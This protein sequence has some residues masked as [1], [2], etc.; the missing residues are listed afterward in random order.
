MKKLTIA[1]IV[2]AS[3]AMIGEVFIYATTRESNDDVHRKA[4]KANYHIYAPVL[5]DT[6]YFAGERVPMNIYYVRESMDRELM[7]NMYWHSN[8]LLYMK[9]AGRFFPVI[10]PI[11]KKNGV[12]EDFKYLCVIESGLQNVTS[13][14]KAQGYW[15]FIKSTGEK[16]GLTINDDIDMR[17]NIEA[18]TEA[19]C[20]YLKDLKQRF[21]SWTS[22]AA[23][24]NCG[25]GGLGRR[26]KLESVNNYYD[27]R[28]NPETARYV[29]RILAVKQIMQH[30]QDYGI[31]IRQCDLYPPIPTQTATLSGRDID[32]Y[33]YARQHNC[34][35]KMLRELNPWLINETIKNK[36][37]RTY[38]VKLPI[39]KGTEMSTIRPE[40]SNELVTKL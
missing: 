18:S 15:Q 36:A 22:A 38:T 8:I 5:P 39:K 3:L 23:A 14:A 34:S 10:E 33:E 27:V 26:Y 16:Y 25:E 9:R 31:Y 2:L 7:V 29:F 19:A 17:N 37:D 12:P 20:R 4:I 21:G 40:N 28:L 24:Y 1:A 32:L 35:Y 6:L 11:L 30:P 13:S